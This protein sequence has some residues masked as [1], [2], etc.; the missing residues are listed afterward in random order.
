MEGLAFRFGERLNALTG[1]F[2]EDAIHFRL[3]GRERARTTSA[4]NPMIAVPT[5]KPTTAEAAVLTI[6]A[7]TPPIPATPC[8]PCSNSWTRWNGVDQPSSSKPTSK[9]WPPTHSIA[10]VPTMESQASS[11]G[12]PV[13]SNIPTRRERGDWRSA[14]RK[15]TSSI[16]TMSATTP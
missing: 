4:S 2:V 12:M 6:Q 10:A 3:V 9:M 16:F 8:T 14:S 13:T 5:A 15:P 11:L 7:R 1:N